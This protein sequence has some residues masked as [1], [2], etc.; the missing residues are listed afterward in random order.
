MPTKRA[1]KPFQESTRHHTTNPHSHRRSLTSLG[2]HE[3]PNHE[4]NEHHA[5]GSDAQRESGFGLVQHL[6]QVFHPVQ[7]RLEHLR[8]SLRGLM[9]VRFMGKRESSQLGEERRAA[10]RAKITQRLILK[11]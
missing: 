5:E 6:H 4:H 1:G 10:E 2:S 11:P 7:S 8:G 3:S 9:G